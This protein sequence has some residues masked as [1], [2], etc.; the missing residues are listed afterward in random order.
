MSA[1]REQRNERRAPE[2]TANAGAKNAAHDDD[3]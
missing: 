3:A 2:L 1:R